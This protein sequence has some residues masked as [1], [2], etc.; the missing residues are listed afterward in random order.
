MKLYQDIMLSKLQYISQGK[1][2]KQQLYNIEQALDAGVKWIQLRFKNALQDELLRLAIEVKMLCEANNAIFII[3]DHPL[4]A[5]EADADGVH[6]GL[7]DEAITKAREILGHDKIIG[8]TANTFEDVVQRIN[9]G[10]NYIGLG[11]YRY[12]T[13]KEKLSPILGAAGYSSIIDAMQQE[14]YNIPVYAIGGI[15]A[16]DVTAI[17]ETG[18]HGIAVSGL[19]TNHPNKKYLIEQLNSFLYEEINHS[20]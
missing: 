5:K 14:Q 13:T 17:M 10:C 11:P 20:G 3:N 8:G 7:Q 16:E 2:A 1:T 19:I 15:T 4:I 9:E 18:V 6:L 12:T